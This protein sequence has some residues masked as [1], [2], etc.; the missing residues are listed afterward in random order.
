MVLKGLILASFLHGLFDFLL[1]VNIYVAFL[2][3]PLMILMGRLTGARIRDLLLLSP[4]SPIKR[5]KVLCP[6]C[7][8]IVQ[9]KDHNLI[10]NIC[11]KRIPFGADMEV[12]CPR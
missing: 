12:H 8:K 9:P 10:C 5:A 11:G 4:Y 2:V 3:L 6:H 7:K 1:T